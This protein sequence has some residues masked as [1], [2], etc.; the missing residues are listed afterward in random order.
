MTVIKDSWRLAS[1]CSGTDPDLF[2][3]ERGASTA[4]AK[5]ICRGCAVRKDCLEF[6]LSSGERSGIWGGMSE[7]ER[8]WIRRQRRTTHSTAN[9]SNVS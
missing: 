8:R 6:A 1:N 4:E 7:Q 3:P 5:S 2:F 9:L